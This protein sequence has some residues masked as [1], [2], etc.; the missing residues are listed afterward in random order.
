M[1]RSYK[2]YRGQSPAL[3]EEPAIAVVIP[4]YLAQ[5]HIQ[6]VLAGIP[7]WVT[8]I[9][10]V[11]DASPDGTAQQAR[12][13]QDSRIVVISHDQNQGVG[14]AVLTGYRK[15]TE[16]GAKI[17]IKMDSDGQMD[18]AY[19]VSL[20]APIV[21][22]RADYSKGNRFLHMDKLRS[23]PFLRRIGNA[24]LS[25]LTKVASGYWNIFDP[26]NGYTAIHASIVPLLN[27]S[28]IH[29]RFFFESSMLIELGVIGAVVRDVHIPANYSGEYS[30]LSEWKALFEFPPRLLAGCLRRLLIEYFIRDF[31]V[32]SILVLLG[33]ALSAFGLVFGLYHWYLSSKM[34]IPASAGTVMLAILPLTLGSQ[35]LMQALFVDIQNVPNEPLSKNVE[36]TADLRDR[37][38]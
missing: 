8:H 28:K 3:E 2:A 4:A 18:P 33:L 5:K 15:A 22:H 7:A 21:L 20:V 29:R 11:D 23:M 36:L 26:T 31:G 30:L 14:G 37:L 35:L 24:G 10:V 1:T 17:V 38:V 25:F 34:G 19:L 16:L 13:V 27:T 12:Q 9:V 32:F 6:A